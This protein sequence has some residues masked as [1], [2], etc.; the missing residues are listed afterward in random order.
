MPKREAITISDFP[1]NLRLKPFNAF[2]DG[3][4]RG[5]TATEF[6]FSRKLSQIR[7]FIFSQDD[8]FPER[9]VFIN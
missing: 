1:K 5:P 2:N 3:M 4:P 6:S 7:S 8:P 9:V